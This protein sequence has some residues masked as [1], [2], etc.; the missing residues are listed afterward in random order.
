MANPH[1]YSLEPINGQHYLSILAAGLLLAGAGRLFGTVHYVDANGT[2]ATPPYTNW[3]TAATKIQDAVDAGVVGDEVVVTNGTYASGGR[4]VYGTL[5]NR[6]AVNKTL[7][8]RSVNGAQF[9]IIQG[10]QLP[11]TRNGE[12]AV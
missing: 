7:T 4:S 3:A 2:N 11:G 12:G 6:V 1:R 8:V 10:H 9:T 5:T